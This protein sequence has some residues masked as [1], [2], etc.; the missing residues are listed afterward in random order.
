[1]GRMPVTVD[2]AA[3]EPITDLVTGSRPETV[4]EAAIVPARASV[5]ADA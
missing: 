5:V 4:D 2:E 3:I 1:M